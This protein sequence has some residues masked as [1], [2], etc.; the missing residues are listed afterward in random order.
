MKALISLLLFYLT[1]LVF[2]EL[3]TEK[4]KLIYLPLKKL[5]SVSGALH[6]RSGEYDGPVLNAN[7]TFI[8]TVNIGTPTQS[9]LCVVDTARYDVI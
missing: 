1:A 6:K 9:L 2:A 7:V 3:Q 5:Q 4:T 8:T